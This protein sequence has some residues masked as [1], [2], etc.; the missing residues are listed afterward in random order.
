MATQEY[1]KEY[2]RRNRD[3][4]LARSKAY[5][6]EHAE[7]RAQYMR[8]Y[9]ER[10]PEKWTLTDDDKARKNQRRREKYAADSEHREKLRAEAKKWQA[11]NPEKRFAQRLSVYGMT[12]EGYRSMLESQNGGCAICAATVSGD[13]RSDRLHVDHCHTTGRVRGLLCSACN[14]GIGKFGDDPERLFRA[15]EY[16]RSH[17]C[18]DNSEVPA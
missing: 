4:R 17:Q 18:V 6:E 5:Q 13:R 16:I 7:E 14:L 11:S 2:Y 3:K 9:R 15:S 8:E 1:F 10:N 12:A